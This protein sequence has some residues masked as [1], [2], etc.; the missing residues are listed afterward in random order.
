MCVSY[1]SCASD[2]LHRY[3]GFFDL[4]HRHPDYQKKAQLL[5]MSHAQIVNEML[6]LLDKDPSHEFLLT[7][8]QANGIA[9]S[10]GP[11][12][13]IISI[14]KLFPNVNVCIVLHLIV[15]LISFGE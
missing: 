8:S 14:V 11:W 3:E 7:S 13:Q 9:S 5:Y 15:Q 10:R 4:E 1:A 6:Q 12:K 2:F